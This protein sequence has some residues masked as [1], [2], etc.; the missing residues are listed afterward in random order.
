MSSVDPA[1]LAVHVDIAR[2]LVELD[3]DMGRASD[4]PVVALS[5]RFESRAPRDEMHP[6]SSTDVSG[7][8]PLGESGRRYVTEDRISYRDPEGQPVDR[9]VW[10]VNPPGLQSVAI[11]LKG[12]H[13]RRATTANAAESIARAV[14]KTFPG[15][16]TV[17]HYDGDGDSRQAWWEVVPVEPGRRRAGDGLEQHPDVER[18]LVAAALC[19]PAAGS[20]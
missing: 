4:P 20:G 18:S 12:A 14:A 13:E 3:R 9:G 1:L 11:V 2:H 19:A 8:A 7:A 5:R 10:L 16:V 6:G 15:H 17:L